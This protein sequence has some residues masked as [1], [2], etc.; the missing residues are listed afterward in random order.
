MYQQ[1]ATYLQQYK[2]VTIPQIGSF[3]LVSQSATLDVASKVIHPPVYLPKYSDRELVREH[4]LNFLAVDLNADKYIVK[5]QLENFGRELRAKIERG[6][7]IWKGVGRLESEDAKMVFHPDVVEIKGLQS[8]PAEKVLRKNVQH[9]VLR[10]E[11]EVLSASF[12]DE[13]KK[14]NKKKSLVNL[15]GWIVVA[16]SIVF[17]IVYVSSDGFKTT[18]SGTKMKL[19]PDSPASTHK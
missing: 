18:S 10:G 13:E 19:V 4:Q 9:T 16:L 7:L 15:I 14:I 11:Q 12:Y 5:E 1:L 8:M 3:E 6:A 17:I 2:Q